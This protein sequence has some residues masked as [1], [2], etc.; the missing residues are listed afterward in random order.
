M[1]TGLVLIIGIVI[2]FALMGLSWA[3]IDTIEKTNKTFEAMGKDLKKI[4]QSNQEIADYD[5]ES[6]ADFW[7]RDNRYIE[8]LE[9]ADDTDSENGNDSK[10][11]QK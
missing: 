8:D 9:G 11:V 7:K 10:E 2:V 4:A 6:S 1:V 5:S 3:L